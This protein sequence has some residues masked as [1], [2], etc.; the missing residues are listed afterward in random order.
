MDAFVFREPRSESKD[1]KS[2]L[3]R[4]SVTTELIK[5]N[6]VVLVNLSERVMYVMRVNIK[7]NDLYTHKSTFGNQQRSF[8]TT[9][10]LHMP[11]ITFI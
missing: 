4:E 7:F 5:R 10:L 8:Q 2:I 3:A 1:I 11:Q 9:I 6:T